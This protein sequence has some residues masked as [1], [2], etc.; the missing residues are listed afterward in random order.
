MIKNKDNIAKYIGE[1]F[2]GPIL[3]PYIKWI[4]KYAIHNKIDKLYFI[5][6]DGYVLKKIA[7]IFIKYYKYPIHT[8]YLYGSRKTWRVGLFIQDEIDIIKLLDESYRERINSILKLAKIFQI[9]ESEMREFLPKEYQKDIK[10]LIIDDIY[11]IQNFLQRSEKFKAFLKMKH[12]SKSERAIQYLKQEINIKDKNF[13]FVE[14]YGSGY[15]QNCMSL[16]LKT[17]Y[18]VPIKTFFYYQHRKQNGDNIFISFVSDTMN[19]KILIETLC[20]SF[21]GQ[22]IDYYISDHIW[23]PLIEENEIL[24]DYNYSDYI[25]GVLNYTENFICN[26]YDIDYIEKWRQ[27]CECKS[28]YVMDYIGD[29]PYGVIG[30]EEIKTYFAPK[31]NLNDIF[32]IAFNGCEAEEQNIYTGAMISYSIKRMDG[33][34]GKLL[35]ILLKNKYIKIMQK[36]YID[37]KS[38]CRIN[39]ID[40]FLN[41]PFMRGKRIVVYGA[42]KIG[43]HIVKRILTEKREILVLWIDQSEKEDKCF[44]IKRPETIVN[45]KFDYVILASVYR[46]YLDS[47]L[48]KLRQ[49]NV[50]ENKIIY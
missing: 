34:K 20:R 24:K 3:V 46:D 42:G 7:D 28:Q 25:D 13:A 47:M 17:F 11:I 31:L 39:K 40:Y 41:W 33:I 27:F 12:A 45:S 4:L 30:S 44:P 37:F 15:T 49:L 16:L 6:R 1:E 50:S 19:I 21:E 48:N 26:H 32:Y 18:N 36:F 10:S 38:N 43:T 5:A 23:K 2:G 22:T 29:M 9:T 14:L 8:Y 35:Y